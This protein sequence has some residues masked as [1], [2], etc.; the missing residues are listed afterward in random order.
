[1]KT[2]VQTTWRWGFMLNLA[3]AGTGKN[4]GEHLL[5]GPWRD[6]ETALA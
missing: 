3:T 2:T 5:A 1:M 4:A 6:S